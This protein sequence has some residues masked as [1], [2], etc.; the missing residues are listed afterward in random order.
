MS[1]PEVKKYVCVICDGDASDNP[2]RPYDAYPPW[3][4]CLKHAQYGFTS[5]FMFPFVKRELGLPYLDSLKTMQEGTGFMKAKVE[6]NV[7]D[8]PLNED[9]IARIKITNA[10][11][12]CTEHEELKHCYSKKWAKAWMKYKTKVNPNAISEKWSEDWMKFEELFRA[13][14]EIFKVE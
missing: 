13:D 2:P 5:Y 3:Q 12:Y 10:N 11:F 9:E 14:S 6:C 1:N 4:C 7:C 8:K